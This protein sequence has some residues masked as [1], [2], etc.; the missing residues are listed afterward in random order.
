MRSKVCR[1]CKLI[2]KSE[3]CPICNGTD[4][5]TKWKGSIIVLNVEKSEVAKKL[6]VSMNGEYAIKTK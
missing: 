4:F 3:T 1:K 5:T 2:V 6:N